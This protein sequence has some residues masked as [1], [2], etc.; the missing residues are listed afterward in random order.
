MIVSIY[1]VVEP[2]MDRVCV[3]TS[4]PFMLERRSGT[5]VYRTEVALPDVV[6]VDGVVASAPVRKEMEILCFGKPSV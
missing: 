1:L 6:L 4:P 2:G 5:K 3:Q